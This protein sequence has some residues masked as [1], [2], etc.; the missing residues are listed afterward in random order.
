MSPTVTWAP[1]A[2]SARAMPR[3]MPPPP[4]VTT[5]TCPSR[6]SL[7]SVTKPPRRSVMG[8][9]CTRGV[10]SGRQ[11]GRRARSEVAGGAAVHGDG[12]TGNPVGL[13]GAEEGDEGGHLRRLTHAARRDGGLRS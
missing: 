8:D 10:R 7:L 1:A 13:H 11:V 6:E 3:P 12:L 4:P 2:A 5:A 9:V